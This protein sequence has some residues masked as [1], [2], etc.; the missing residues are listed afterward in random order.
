MILYRSSAEDLAEILMKPSLRGPCMKILQMP[1]IR[2][3]CMKAL[4]GG[5]GGSWQVL[6]PIAAAG[7]CMTI[8]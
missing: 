8:L 5:L 1:C 6:V 3:A 4:L 7:P 2:G